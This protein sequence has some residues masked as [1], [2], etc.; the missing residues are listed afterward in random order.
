MNCKENIPSFLSQKSF[1]KDSNISDGKDDK[2]GRN[3]VSAKK[4]RQKKKA[5]IN[6]LESRYIKLEAELKQA[7][8]MAQEGKNSINSKI[9]EVEARE[10]EY[11]VLLTQPRATNQ[12]QHNK[13]QNEE[14]KIKFFHNKMQSSLI[15]ELYRDLIKSIVPLDVKYF[16]AKCA[17]LQDIYKFSTIDEFLDILV[18][19][20]YVLNESYNF[21]YA[22]DATASFPFQ[23]YMFYE[24]LKKMTLDFKEHVCQVRK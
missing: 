12:L 22:S 9:Q 10:K 1:R 11:F 24:H 18:Q 5:Y 17:N 20:Q 8:K 15:V 19:N 14:N 21:Q 3:R 13:N 23:V 6:S 7:K 2:L 4:S 16:E